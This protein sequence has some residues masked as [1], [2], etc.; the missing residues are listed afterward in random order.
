MPNNELIIINYVSTTHL[1]SLHRNIPTLLYWARDRFIIDDG[2]FENLQPLLDTNIIHFSVQSLVAHLEEIENDILAWWYS[3]A[4]QIAR[5]NFL[6]LNCNKDRT[7]E[8]FL[9][10]IANNA[11]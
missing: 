8:K 9:T 2:K 11:S 6:K 10:S 3:P 1:E 4:V 5:L 7:I